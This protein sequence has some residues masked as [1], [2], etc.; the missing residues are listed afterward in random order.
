MAT[1]ADIITDAVRVEA[2]VHE[3]ADRRGRGGRGLEAAAVLRPHLRRRQRQARLGVDRPAARLGV[4]RKVVI[5]HPCVFSI[6]N[7]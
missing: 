6:H 2:R 7:H 1:L 4:G 5:T 3:A